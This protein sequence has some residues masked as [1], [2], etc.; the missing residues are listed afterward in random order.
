M[1]SGAR[2]ANSSNR[3]AL[4]LQRRDGGQ[5][6]LPGPGRAFDR[7]QHAELANPALARMRQTAHVMSQAQ[8]WN[9]KLVAKLD[10]ALVVLLPGHADDQQL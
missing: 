6:H 4:C 5:L 3:A 9:T 2:I 8:G 1:Y 7:A 10:R